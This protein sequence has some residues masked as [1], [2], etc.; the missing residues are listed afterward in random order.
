MCEAISGRLVGEIR[1]ETELKFNSWMAL[2]ISL[3]DSETRTMISRD[4]SETAEI[5]FLRAVKGCNKKDELRNVDLRTEL[6]VAA[7]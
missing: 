3:Y 5:K 1:K 6:R 4:S 2:P 7:V